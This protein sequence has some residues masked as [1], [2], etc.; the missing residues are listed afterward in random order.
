MG[1]RAATT[2]LI[3]E[4]DTVTL[5]IKKTPVI[6]L[7]ARPRPTMNKQYRDPGRI[8]ALL[9]M[10]G[11]RGINLQAVLD[12]GMNIRIENMHK[13]EDSALALSLHDRAATEAIPVVVSAS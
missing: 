7:T 9:Q 3:E 8:A 5:R 4:N 6:R 1:S 2:T 12:E 13:N 10:Q 11:V